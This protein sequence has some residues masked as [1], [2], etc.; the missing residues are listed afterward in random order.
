MYQDQNPYDDYLDG[1]DGYPGYTPETPTT[2]VDVPP[3]SPSS[4]PAAPA[5]PTAIT[6]GPNMTREQLI[7]YQKQQAAARGVTLRDDTL[8][9]WA[10]R[11][12]SPEFNGDWQFWGNRF[13]NENEDFGYRGTGTGGGSMSVDPS[14]LSPFT[15]DFGAAYRQLF[16]RDFADFKGPDIDAL[17]SD[18]GYQ[19]RVSQSTGALQ[20]S[21]AARGLLNSGGTL[22][23]IL[24]LSDQMA[25]QEYGA[26]WDRDF[27]KWNADADRAWKSYVENKDTWYRNQDEPFNKLYRAG[28]LGFGAASA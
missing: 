16:G 5:T 9:Y 14:Y 24:G 13:N 25:A 12:Y 21:A 8:D 11:Y 6:L 22:Y 26:A 1:Y 18:P 27:S 20:N 2:P 17:K 23:D 4:G 19:F 10:N 3:T 28:Q 7:A 15:S